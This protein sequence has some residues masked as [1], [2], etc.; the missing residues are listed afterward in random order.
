[1][2]KLLS[3]Y[4]FYEFCHKKMIWLELEFRANVAITVN[5]C[6]SINSNAELQAYLP[7]ATH[8][9]FLCCHKKE[10]RDYSS[11]RT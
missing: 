11:I 3:P 8:T 9:F 5:R 10:I 1:M 6:S 4:D 7:T 2:I